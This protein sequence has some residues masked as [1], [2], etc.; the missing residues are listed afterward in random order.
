MVNTVKLFKDLAR[1]NSFIIGVYYQEL[2]VPFSV[3][4]EQDKLEGIVKGLVKE[5]K[6]RKNKL[7]YTKEIV[8]YENKLQGKKIILG[9]GIRRKMILFNR[10]GV[11]VDP[12][13]ENHTK[14]YLLKK[15][16][17]PKKD[18]HDFHSAREYDEVLLTFGFDINPEYVDFV[19]RNVE[20]INKNKISNIDYSEVLPPHHLGEDYVDVRNY[21]IKE[22]CRQGIK[23]EY[24][25]DGRRNKEKLR[26][27]DFLNIAM[28]DR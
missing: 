1:E 11:G 7:S 18:H 12:N 9:D 25:T 23:L 2:F 24:Y 22:M 8:E 28:S 16:I 17:N 27:A 5:N 14:V 6:T 26:V 13:D 21:I 19:R 3:N 20:Y 4:E 10:V 15:A